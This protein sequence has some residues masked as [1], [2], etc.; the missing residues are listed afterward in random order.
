MTEPCP[1]KLPK[2]NKDYMSKKKK[3]NPSQ[4]MQYK[5]SFQHSI[6]QNGGWP[7][8]FLQYPWSKHTNCIF[9]TG[10]LDSEAFDF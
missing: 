10:E 9:I 8:K 7:I 6:L 3:T 4:R 2:T 5:I 1:E